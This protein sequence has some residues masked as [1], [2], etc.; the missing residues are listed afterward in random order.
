MPDYRCVTS[1]LQTTDI[2][3]PG[4]SG[5]KPIILHKPLTPCTIGTQYSSVC[6]RSKEILTRIFRNIITK[7]AFFRITMIG[8]KLVLEHC[9]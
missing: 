9:P 8:K 1:T 5:G 4:L 2:D 7:D 3:L 6:F